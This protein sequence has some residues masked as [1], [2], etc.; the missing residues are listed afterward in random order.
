MNFSIRSKFWAS[1]LAILFTIVGIA[2]AEAMQVFVKPL[3]GSTIVLDVE[4]SDTIE[5]VKTKIQDKEGIPPDQQR[6]IFAGHVLEDGRTLSDYNILREATLHLVLINQPSPVSA[7]DPVQQS[8]VISLLPSFASISASAEFV[9]NGDFIEQISNISVDGNMLPRNS[10]SQSKEVVSFTFQFSQAGKHSIQLFNG[11]A[12]LLHEQLVEVSA[13][14]PTPMAVSMKKAPLKI[15][16][17]RCSDRWR[18]RHL[19][20]ADATCPVGYS[21]S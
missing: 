8:K 17:S 6:L 18:I 19:I 16:Y 1:F 11:S 15:I 4:P 5:N 14:E 20:G 9:I 12:P 3:S 7:P 2:S 10:W 13:P 21:K